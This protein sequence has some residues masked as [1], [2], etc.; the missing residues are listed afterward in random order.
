MGGSEGPFPARGIEEREAR[1]VQERPDFL[2]EPPDPLGPRPRRRVGNGRC[3]EGVGRVVTVIDRRSERLRD[4]GLQVPGKV[5]PQRPERPHPA[6][7]DF[8]QR[9]RRGRALADRGGIGDGADESAQRRCMRDTDVV[10]ESE[11]REEGSAVVA[12]EDVRGFDVAVDETSPVDSAQGKPDRDRQSD[13]AGG[14]AVLVAAGPFPEIRRER[15][16]VDPFGGEGWDRAVLDEPVHLHDVRVADARE[17]SG[18][19]PEPRPPGRRGRE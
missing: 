6:A 2:G 17:S 8:P 3:G 4:D 7:L 9:P 15:S 11:V 5:G 19:F 1:L 12:K 10:G 18:L 14:I 16:P 13:V